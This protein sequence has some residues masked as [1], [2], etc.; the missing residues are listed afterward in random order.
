[1]TA[2]N[3]FTKERLRISSQ[4][5]LTFTPCS[6]ASF[7]AISIKCFEKSK[8]VIL[9][10]RFANS[11][12]CLPCPHAKS[13][14]S[15]PFLSWSRF[16][17]KGICCLVSFGVTVSTYVLRYF[18]SNRVSHHCFLDLVIKIKKFLLPFQNKV[19]TD[20]ESNCFAILTGQVFFTGSLVVFA[21]LS[22]A[23]I[24]SFSLAANSFI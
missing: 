21:S 2:S 12:A 16:S 11:I 22:E 18:S 6:L 4:I 5:K 24:S 1:M 14:I 3:L 15:A 20:P 19:R 23:K 8:P 10:L 9:Y 7:L 17:K 13:K